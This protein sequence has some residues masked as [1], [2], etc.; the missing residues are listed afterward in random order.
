MAPSEDRGEAK[1][2]KGRTGLL[3]QPRSPAS[4]ANDAGPL[5]SGMAGPNLFRNIPWKTVLPVATQV[6]QE[7]RETLRESRQ[8]RQAPGS[9]PPPG[10]TPGN[11]SG[12]LTESEVAELRSR[13]RDLERHH[14]K[15]VVLAERLAEGQ[16]KQTRAAASLASQMTAVF[17][18]LGLTFLMGLVALIVAVAT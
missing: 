5:S 4:G 17:V 8:S 10:S 11:T 12:S 6:A 3:R 1:R 7:L 16:E 14:D 9:A 13:L 18:L 15:V 2:E